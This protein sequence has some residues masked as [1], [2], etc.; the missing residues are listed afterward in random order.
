MADDIVLVISLDDSSIDGTYRKIED[1][2]KDAA[3]SSEKSFKKSFQQTEKDAKFSF[4]EIGVAASAGLLIAAGSVSKLDFGLK[5][6]RSGFV[7]STELSTR[8]ASRVT[9]LS[10]LFSGITEVFK[11]SS[12][13]IFG[14]AEILGITSAGLLTLS[15]ALKESDS[16]LLRFAG[17]VSLVAGLITGGLS[18]AIF[19]LVSL[20]GDLSIKIGTELVGFNLKAVESFA[21]LEKSTVI[22]TRTLEGF[23]RVFQSSLGTANEWNDAI[24][25]ISDRT[26]ISIS[27]LRKSVAEL[28]AAG[29]QLDLS[30]GQI[31]EL[32]DVVVDYSTI[33]GDVF[34]TTVDFVGGLQGNTQALVKYGIKLNEAS[35]QQALYKNGIEASVKQL[36]EG[37]LSQARLLKVLTLYPTI[38]GK[39][40]AV[41]N[42]LAGSQEKLNNQIERFRFAFGEGAAVIENVDIAYFGLTKVLDNVN[43]GFIKFAGLISGITGRLLQL[44]GLGLKLSFIFVAITKA[45]ALM[46]VVLASS[47]IQGF[48]DFQIPFLNKSLRQTLVLLGAT[49]VSLASTKDVLLSVGSLLKNLV[50]TAISG[51]LG[52]AGQTLSLSSILSGIFKRSFQI[53]SLAARA[54]GAS[55]RFLFTNP[56]GIAITAAIAALVLLKNAFQFIEART[57]AFSRTWQIMLNIFKETSSVLEPIYKLFQ[58]IGNFLATVF[59]KA[60]GLTVVGINKLFSTI[61][62]L[63]EKNP[64]GVF[65]QKTV[66]DVRAV[67]AELDELSSAIIGVGFDIRGIRDIAS[68]D[69][70]PLKDTRDS[71]RLTKLEYISLGD[72]IGRAVSSEQYKEAFDAIKE[73]S[74]TAEDA[75]KRGLGTAV[76]LIKQQAR[77]VSQVVNTLVVEGFSRLGAALVQGEKGFAGFAKTVAGILGDFFIQMGLTII[78]ADSAIIALKASLVSFFG[79]AGIATGIGLVVAG[80]ALKALSGGPAGTATS[81]ALGGAGGGDDFSSIGAPTTDLNNEDLV[82]QGPQVNVNIQGNIL[83]RRE[84]GLEIANIIR[85]SFDGNAVVFNT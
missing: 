74:L 57:G 33:T 9:D 61:L 85:E 42:T 24:S 53:A 8:F 76:D 83:D 12:K 64:F 52:I 15:Q 77:A 49:N 3:Q 30:R 84:T 22:F 37:S 28:V 73:G 23:Q 55:L 29:A 39:A 41:S 6:L 68:A 4:K 56:I 70:D 54:F 50:T 47:T 16:K 25:D 17:T 40:A 82:A 14:L 38:A 2:A 67:K 81:T 45:V 72:E 10:R 71:I 51:L 36:D 60:I 18:I 66:M 44:I 34:Q 80:G 31:R 19:K 58:T 78:A 27:D 35:V 5:A 48:I 75:V 20:V 13:N 32:L 1:S 11:K 62:L 59:F 26:G 69:G 7:A 79:G 43:V 65:S 63:V 21:K 46:N